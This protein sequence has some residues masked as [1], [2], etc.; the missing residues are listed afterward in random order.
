MEGRKVQKVGLKTLAVS[1]PKRWV[2]TVGIKH[3]DLIMFDIQPDN[4]LVLRPSNMAQKKEVE[5]SEVIYSDLCDRPNLLERVIIGS[6]IFGTDTI[7]I[8]SSRRIGGSCVETTRRI[9]HRLM[10]MGIVQ[11]TTNEIVLQCSIDPTKFPVDI[12]IRRLYVIVS[13]M[14]RD[15]IQAL[16]NFNI[17]LAKEV[18]D[19]ENEANMV[20]WLILRILAWTQKERRLMLDMSI[21]N[22]FQILGLWSISRYLERMGDWIKN[23]AELILTLEPYSKSIDG[24]ELDRISELSDVAYNICYLAIQSLYKRDLKLANSVIDDYKRKLEESEVILP[25]NEVECSLEHIRFAIRRIGE[26]GAEIAE[27]IIDESVG[28]PNEVCEIKEGE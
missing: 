14:H 15:A 19:R 17:D 9:A 3:G 26:L 7:R 4:S 11:E 22:T 2:K 13:T 6:Y 12:L 16:V 10:G 1:L 5:L 20:Y 23:M 24:R 8:V 28:S 21:E 18:I 25:R 27:T